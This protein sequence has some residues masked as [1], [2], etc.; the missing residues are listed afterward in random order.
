VSTS[1]VAELELVR[2]SVRA[3][4]SEFGHEYYAER[5]AS[6]EKTTELWQAVGAAGFVGVNLPEEYGGGGL[7]IR[8]LAAVAEELAALG[9]PLLM[10]V[11]SPAICGAVISRFGTEEQR[12]RWV[13]PI[14]SGESIMAFAITEP[15]AG[16]NSHNL[17]TTAERDG[18][19]W[20]LRGTKYFI[21]GVDEADAILVVART[22]TDERTGRG[23]LSLFVVDVDAP[24][25]ERAVIPVEIRAPELQFT[26]FLD[27]VRLEGDR[28]I[29]EEG[30]GLK[31]IFLGLNPERIMTAAGGL[32]IGRYALD[33][34]VAYARQRSVWGRPIGEHQGIAHPLAEA[35]IELELA[36]VMTERA[37]E[38]YDAGLDAGEES[39]MAKLAAADA[40]LL[41][42]DRAIQ[43][44]GGNGLASEVGLA[45]L[46]GYARLMR[47]APVSREMVLNYVAQHS[48]GLPKSY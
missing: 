32:G 24:G 4:G 12:Q 48:L 18:D 27:G 38:L 21:S 35:K 37:A 1:N 14:A 6:G 46:W 44:H 40:A 41:C 45:D 36:R 26:L 20:V 11:V 31:Q 5:A 9:C 25:L 3:I 30:E 23:R 2:E 28:L 33:K 17:T 43:T 10:L 42:L 16:S 15:D 8:E 19:G 39:N 13:P 29:G 22:G 47:I 7:G 34:A